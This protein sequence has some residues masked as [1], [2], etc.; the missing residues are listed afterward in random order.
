MDHEISPAPAPEDEEA[1]EAALARLLQERVDPYSAWWR[2]G[3]RENLDLE[4]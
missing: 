4:S 1:I 3:V 2:E